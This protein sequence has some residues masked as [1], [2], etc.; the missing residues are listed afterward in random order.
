MK[1]IEERILLLADCKRKKIKQKHLASH[2]SVSSAW[3]SYFFSG[4]A[5]LSAQHEQMLIEYINNK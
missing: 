4:T 2:L 3:I 5:D 1:N